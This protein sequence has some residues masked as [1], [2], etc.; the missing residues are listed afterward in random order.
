[1][2]SYLANGSV[3]KYY[4]GGSNTDIRQTSISALCRQTDWLGLG[5]MYEY[6]HIFQKCVLC[7]ECSMRTINYQL[8]TINYQLTTINYQLST[9]N[10]Q[11]STINYQLSTIN[12]QLSTINYQLS[13]HISPHTM[14]TTHTIQTLQKKY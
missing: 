1:M 10:Y 8:S 6:Y 14:H 9:I 3:A 4:L 7:I 13:T 11:L 2:S 5:S 12:Y